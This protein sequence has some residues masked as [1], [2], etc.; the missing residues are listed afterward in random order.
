[1]ETIYNKKNFKKMNPNDILMYLDSG[2]ELNYL[3]RDKLLEYIESVKIK[4]ILGT[5]TSSTDYS[6][7][8]M[9]LIKYF[10]LQDNIDLLKQN[11]I[12]AGILMMLN[13]HEI[14][15]LYEEY[16]DIGSNNYFLID[17]SKSKEKNFKEFIE[18]RHDQSI[19]NL[20]VK[21]CPILCFRNKTGNSILE[22]LLTD[23]DNKK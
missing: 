3:A 7:T 20:L 4:K 2:C 5:E 1:M 13:C 11:H 22:T 19:F 18:H 14:K 10:N 21:K 23:K 16:Y 12:Q 8:K 15:K 9:D 17:D 6:Y